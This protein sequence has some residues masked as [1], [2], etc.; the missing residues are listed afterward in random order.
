MSAAV[1]IIVGLFFLIGIT[2]GVVIVVAMAGV[3]SDRRAG[4]GDPRYERGGRVAEPPAAGED[5]RTSGQRPGWPGDSGS[6]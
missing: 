6:W 5:D 3:R 2:V 4:P 1:V